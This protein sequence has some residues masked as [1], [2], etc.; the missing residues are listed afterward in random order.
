MSNITNN[1][2]IGD[3]VKCINNKPLYNNVVAPPVRLIEYKV[4][5]KHVCKCGNISYD[6]GLASN[7]GTACSKCL[8]TVNN[9]IIHW[10]AAERFIKAQ[11]IAEQIAE[12]VREEKYELAHELQ[13]LETI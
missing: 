7:N 6:V 4:L 5:G 8:R 3:I 1:I 12:A 9:D 10:C 11:P 2:K 13:Q